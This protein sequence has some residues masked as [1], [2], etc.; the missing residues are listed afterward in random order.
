VL[1][2]MLV[3]G[4][5]TVWGPAEMRV[6]ES[7]A[8]VTAVLAAMAVA[9]ATGTIA[10]NRLSAFLPKGW[11]RVASILERVGTSLR[12]YATTPRVMIYASA[13]SLLLQ[14]I[15]VLTVYLLF[16][17]LGGGVSFAICLMV[18]PA[19]FASDMIPGVG[20]RLGTEQGVFVVLFGFFG[21]TPELAF[22]VSLV[23]VAIGA[24][25][26]LPGAIELLRMRRAA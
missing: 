25:V 1:L 9:L 24:L 7:I 3:G 13:L 6:Q 11:H 16:Q 23:N 2:T 5:W 8:L 21:V 17:A 26:N 15:R 20:S 4:W 19:V 22:G 18:V 12:Q 10:S 14:G